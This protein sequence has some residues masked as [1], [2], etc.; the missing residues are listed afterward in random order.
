MS[1]LVQSWRE[2]PSH[3]HEN[4]KMI[5]DLLSFTKMTRNHTL[6]SRACWVLTSIQNWNKR[7]QQCWFMPKTRWKKNSQRAPSC[8]VISAPSHLDILCPSISMG[9]ARPRLNTGACWMS[10]WAESSLRLWKWSSWRMQFW[11]FLLTHNVVSFQIAPCKFHHAQQ[12]PL[13]KVHG[14][15]LQTSPVTIDKD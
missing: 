9:L 8:P 12:S 13:W 7:W 14:C 2:L 3:G 1:T 15:S 5:I 4:R 6:L 10:L 11:L